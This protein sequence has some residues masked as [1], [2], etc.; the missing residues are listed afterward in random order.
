MTHMSA[1]KVILQSV[2]VFVYRMYLSTGPD[3]P[4]A[5]V[6]LKSQPD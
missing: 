3:G 2:G 6:R 1:R 5:I 4:V